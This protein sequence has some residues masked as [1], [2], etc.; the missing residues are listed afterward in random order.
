MQSANFQ[1]QSE[2]PKV[3]KIK[4][5]CDSA[6]YWKTEEMPLISNIEFLEISEK[7]KLN[8]LYLRKRGVQYLEC[9]ITRTTHQTP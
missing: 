4:I 8:Q 7:T 6:T 1:I 3:R 2:A 5:S 9:I